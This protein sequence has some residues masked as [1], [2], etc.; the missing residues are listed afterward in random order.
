MPSLSWHGGSKVRFEILGPLRVVDATGESSSVSA[1]KIEVLLAVLLVRSGQVVPTEQ[2]IAEI[3]GENAPRRAI[4][5]LHVYISNLRK[6]LNR[7]GQHCRIVTRP[8]G[9]LLEMGGDE[10]DL[11]AFQRLVFQGR[12]HARG[13]RHEEAVEAFESALDL[14]RGTVLGD[15]RDGLVISGFARW[16]EEARLECIEL[17]VESNLA[18]DRHREMVGYLYSLITEYPLREAF[19]R[20][21]MLALYRSDRQA[22]ALHVYQVAWERLNDEVGLQPCRALRDLQRAILMTDDRLDARTA[23]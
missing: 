12:S 22:D 21:L 9:Y 15:L 20:Q 16:L 6:F 17:F 7:P 19:Y 2:L 23:V 4:A 10:L 11:H 1:R 14:W 3:W 8:P 18:L 13:H 5:G